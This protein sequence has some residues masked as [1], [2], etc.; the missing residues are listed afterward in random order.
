MTTTSNNRSG[1]DRALDGLR[2][3]DLTS[4][5]AQNCARI[6]GDLGADVI[7]VEPPGGDQA[8]LLAPFAGGSPDPERSLRFLNAN[9][10]KRSVVLD[11]N[12]DQDRARV[13]VLAE[14]VDIIVEDFEPG[15]LATI[16]LGYSDLSV[17]NPGLVY[18]SITP[19]GQTGPNASH[20]GGDLISQATG[21]I[22]FANGDDTAAPVRAPYEIVS[23]MACLHAAF[24]T[25]LAIRA[26]G[27]LGGQGQHVDLS[28]QEAVLWSQGSYISRYS[29][30]DDISRR[31]GHHSAFGA[32]NTYH[33]SDDGYVNLSCY[34][35]VH[36]ARLAKEVMDH[37]ILSDEMWLDRTLRMENRE[38]VDSF[39][40]EYADTVTRD[41]FVDRA[42]GIGLPIVPVLSPAEYVNHPHPAERGFWEESTH[43]VIGDFRT[44]GPPFHMEKTPFR[45]MRP[46]PLLGEHTEE[47][48]SELTA[49][50][51][52]SST[53]PTAASGFTQSVTNGKKPLDGVRII[54]FTR[55]FA[56]PIATMFLGFFGAEVIK[57]E[58]A[59]LDDNRSPGQSTFAD[60]N[61]SKISCTID[62]RTE[63]GR[64]L[65]KQLV[66][67]GGIV[68]ENFR[69]RVM[70]RMGI[71]YE[72]LKKIRPDVIMLAMPGMGNSGPLRD[73]FCYGQQI[74]GVAGLTYLWGHADGAMDTRIKMPFADYVAAILGALS[75]VTALQFRDRTGEGQF[76]ELAQL[77]GAA[78]L[79]NVGSLDYI[80]N[81]I[82]PEPVGNRSEIVGPHGVYPSMGH[83]AWCAIEVETDEQWRALI[84]AMGNPA[85][86]SD[87]RF[88]SNAGRVAA[89]Q[90]LD[91]RL[92]AWT[93]G[94]TN[95]Q[96]ERLLQKVG[97]P[98]GI[99]ANGEDLFNDLHLRS[100]PDV[101]AEA[102]HQDEGPIEHQGINVHLSA[103][104][105]KA[106]PSPAKGQHNDY[107]YRE[108]LGIEANRQQ[109]LQATGA[110][111]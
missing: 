37:P 42:Q 10:S 63:E 47:V 58:S 84:G 75:V 54:D 35:A 85:W 39:V 106:G 83:D 73:Y 8:R 14:R 110:L 28:R 82:A 6:L 68:V 21:G 40:Q 65:I 45:P 44:A 109:E 74:M 105:G 11:L 59:D 25:L 61:R 70:E 93:A 4:Y 89:A 55:A 56:G 88:H 41:D 71:G 46:A 92:A 99:V 111:T 104:P 38:V 31:E 78:H 2:V 19:F 3:L 53:E 15:Y 97:V 24:G 103:T 30:Q 94:Y 101:I 64:T 96:V 32:V 90:E 29:L 79:L 57:V 49:S 5:L 100:R 91:E 27:M 107:V 66:A 20:V 95:R 81:G 48:L 23:Q 18:V 86:A 108:I 34:N 87:D 33:T 17:V 77:E 13:V 26:R 9:R 52:S 98:A 102:V 69:P 60:L 72:E 80:I 12:S 43:P 51:L 62:G 36:F 1:P 50:A 7:K 76:I 67:D 22:M 16:G